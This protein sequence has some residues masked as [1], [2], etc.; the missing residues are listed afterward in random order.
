M[1]RRNFL[2]SSASLLSPLA[3]VAPAQ[4]SY[5]EPDYAALLAQHDT[6]YLTPTAEKSESLPIGNGDLVGMVTMP[7]HGLDLVINKANLWDDRPNDPPLPANWSW[8]IGEEELWTSIVSGC[9]WR[10]AAPC[11]YWTRFASTISRRA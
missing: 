6:V 4:S 10:F 1:N 2:Q 8:D 9:H 11:R 5:P 3:G 7:P